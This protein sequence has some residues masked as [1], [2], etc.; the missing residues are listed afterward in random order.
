MSEKHGAFRL[1]SS[2]DNWVKVGNYSIKDMSFYGSFL[3]LCGKIQGEKV[4]DF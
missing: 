3:H 1:I 2:G 4:Q